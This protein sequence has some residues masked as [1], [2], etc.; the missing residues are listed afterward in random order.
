MMCRITPIHQLKHPIRTPKF[1][2]IPLN[3]Q[4]L[5]ALWNSQSIQ[6]PY[7]MI[8]REI[9][10]FWAFASKCENE[11]LFYYKSG[12]CF[13]ELVDIDGKNLPG[14]GKSRVPFTTENSFFIALNTSNHVNMV[15]NDATTMLLSAIIHR[16]FHFQ[17]TSLNINT[18]TARWHLI[19][20]PNK[21]RKVSRSTYQ[22][23]I[24]A[25]YLYYL[26][27]SRIVWYIPF[28]KKSWILPIF[29]HNNV[30]PFKLRFHKH[31]NTPLLL[32]HHDPSDL[33]NRYS[34]DNLGRILKVKSA[35]ARL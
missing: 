15:S 18:N 12:H 19:I 9:N 22:I 2:R 35:T 7:Q 30:S 16:R 23:Y 27:I 17:N 5:P 21:R 20:T 13:A 24:L 8:S 14:L 6:I 4:I 1:P 34:P 32:F 10:F 26:R 29:I 11:T 31:F 3:L 33:E 25:V 28:V